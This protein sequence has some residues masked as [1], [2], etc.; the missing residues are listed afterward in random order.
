M[1]NPHSP[2]FKNKL[3]LEW[4]LSGTD[5]KIFREVSE[6]IIDT[7]RTCLCN[8]N[9]GNADELNFFVSNEDF[10]KK[11]R[12]DKQYKRIYDGL[13]AWV[14]DT[15][16]PEYRVNLLEKFI[17]GNRAGIEKTPVGYEK[18]MKTV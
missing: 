17:N 11:I 15:L 10:F 12:G 6:G 7:Y 13:D 3:I 2:S 14:E 4:F 5:Q 16:F 1:E 8:L 9:C 18:E